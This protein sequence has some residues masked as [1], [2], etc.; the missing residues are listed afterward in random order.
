MPLSRF[1]KRENEKE[2]EKESDSLDLLRDSHSRPYAEVFSLDLAELDQY[3]A[4][5]EFCARM[6]RSLGSST[7]SCFIAS[8]M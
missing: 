5:V 2:Y 8:T 1:S 6:P 3:G 4:E 7:A